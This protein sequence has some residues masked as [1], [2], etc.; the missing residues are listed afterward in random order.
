MNDSR[1]EP[2]PSINRAVNKSKRN[3]FYAC[4]RKVQRLLTAKSLT[5]TELHRATEISRGWLGK[6][7]KGEGVSPR[8]VDELCR[9]LNVP[10]ES[11]Q[12]DIFDGE[13]ESSEAGLSLEPPKAWE[14]S[15]YL[16]PF[17]Q[18]PNGLSYRIVK[19][20]HK[21]IEGKF[22]RA[23]FYDI[24]HINPQMR[25]Q[26]REHLTRHPRVCQQIGK[27]PNIAE[28]LDV[29]PIENQSGW[30]VIDSWIDGTSMEDLCSDRTLT[31]DVNFL[32]QIGSC[33][34]SGLSAMH[35]AGVIFRELA[36]DKVWVSSK[37]DQAVLTD[38]EL[39]KLTNGAPSV[40]DKWEIGYFRA[41]EIGDHDAFP[42][43]DLYSFGRLVLWMLAG[44]TSKQRTLEDNSQL[45]SNVEKMVQQCLL[46]RASKRPPSAEA[47]LDVWKEWK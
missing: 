38:F 3:A 7:A 28:N 26:F 6:F 43:S 10:P 41:P 9:Y 42:Q 40:S 16:G 12:N 1:R 27:H 14:I 25:D 47:V 33:I 18:A 20:S 5:V 13:P 21:F 29:F 15:Q 45:P 31:F 4:P 44:G 19:L 23:K 32:Q 30:W 37:S 8:V 36:P 11:L 2:K 17:K 22:A 24:V 35:E 34:L 46:V 39:A